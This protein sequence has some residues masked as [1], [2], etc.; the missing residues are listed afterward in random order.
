MSVIALEG[1]KFYAHHG[2]YDE[3]TI[4]G[5]EYEVDVF[6]QTDITTAA[7]TD[8]LEQTINYEIIYTICEIEMRKPAKLIENVVGR[9]MNRIKN[10]YSYIEGI[11]IKLQKLNPPLGGKV[12]AAS[13]EITDE[14][15]LQCA[16]CGR[17]MVCYA[18]ENCWCNDFKKVHPRT[19]EMLR[20]Q[21]G[22]C[23]CSN[24]LGFYT[25]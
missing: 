25:G 14:F 1:M 3:E 15:T 4:L 7:S 22:S 24:C 21:Y 10:K 18:D 23:I 6:I 8:D 12:R 9:I 20:Q 2:Y 19:A 13:I 5:G 16:K 11:T 17:G